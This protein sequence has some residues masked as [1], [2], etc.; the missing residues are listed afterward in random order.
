[1]A[2]GQ[3]EHTTLKRDTE[4]TGSSITTYRRQHGLRLEGHRCA[5][6]GQAMLRKFHRSFDSLF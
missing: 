3:H 5:G 1:M 2:T 4:L 6:E